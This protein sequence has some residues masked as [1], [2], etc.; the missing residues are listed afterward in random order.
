MILR[1]ILG[2][3]LNE[4]HSWFGKSEDDVLYLMMEIIPEATYVRHHVQKLAGFFLAMRSFARTIESKGHHLF[5]IR[6]DDPENRQSFESNIKRVMTK[7]DITKIEY[8]LP[9]EY[10]VDRLLAD[11]SDRIDLPCSSVD[12]EHFL[13]RREDLGDFFASKKRMLME[14]FYRHLRKRDN[15]LMDRQ[16]PVGGQW[17]FDKS[18][19]QTYD[20]S[21]PIPPALEFDHTATEIIDM[22]RKM[23][24]NSFGYI[25]KDRFIWP[26]D[27]KQS[28]ALLDYFLENGLPYFGSFQDAMSS[29]S[30]SM[31]HSR[32]S[33]S[34]NTKMIHP[35]EVIQRTIDYVES[36]RKDIQMNQLEGFIRQILGWREYMRGIYWNLMPGFNDMN[37]FEHDRDLPKFYWDG[38]T[39]MN[40]MKQAI[41][42]S[43][44]FAYAHHI[45]RLMITGN[46][47]LLAGVHPDQVDYW[48]LGIYIDAIE[49]VEKPNTRGMSQFADGGIIATKPY[50]SSANYIRKMSDYCA[51]CHYDHSKRAGER[52]C[53]FNSL[54]WHFYHRNRGKLEG[55]PRITMMYRVWDNM[56]EEDKR[57]IVQ[58]AER[59]LMDLDAL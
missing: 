51:H 58:Q 17:N 49:W 1:L 55:N 52:S 35:G 14:S 7:F 31:F 22:C 23:N 27:R 50:V 3:Q 34:L 26:I 28:L 13:T 24:I 9:D 57:D 40:C 4:T 16:S 29:E 38:Q 39:K 36:S 44:Y 37:Y 30:W 25:E 8:I 47:A 18:N 33:F 12:S 53:P 32:L 56:A 46:F 59:Y 5:Y 11:L 42:Q 41:C 15:I 54:Y 19:R 21:I 48:Y 2:D 43:L 10:R 6:L 20:A 45:Q